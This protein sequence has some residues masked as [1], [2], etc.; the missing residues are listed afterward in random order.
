MPAGNMNLSAMGWMNC[1]RQ[2]QLRETGKEAVVTFR[3]KA[4]KQLVAK[5]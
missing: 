1:S 5:G 4:M 2:T 3:R